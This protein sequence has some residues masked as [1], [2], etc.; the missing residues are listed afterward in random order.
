MKISSLFA[1]LLLG[2]SFSTWAQSQVSVVSS[3]TQDFNSLGTALPDGWGV[4]TDSTTTGNG[5]AFTWSTAIV[6]NNASA[7]ATNYFRNI[8]GSSQTWSA[9]LSSGSDR[10]L[11]WRAGNAASRDG[12]ITFTLS[13]TENWSFTSLGF[14]LF[15][16]NSAGTAGTFQLEY[17]IG[18]SGTFAQLASVSY[19]NDTA[20]NPLIVTSITLNGAQLSV[21]NNQSGQVTLRLNNTATSGTTWNTLAVDNF[22]YQAALSSV[23][24]PSTYAAILGAVALVSVV[25]MRRRKRATI[26]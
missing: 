1:L 24:E 7:S 3:Y 9:G 21:L 5:A 2:T 13:N 22:T 6:A 8:P 10:A 18:G 4:W 20:Q 17:Q 11:G 14:D 16:P 12:S 25:L 23:P 19:T 26:A 15:T